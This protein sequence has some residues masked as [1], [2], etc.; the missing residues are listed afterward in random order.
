[1][2]KLLAA[3]RPFLSKEVL[4]SLQVHTT[5]ESLHKSIPKELLPVEYGG[6][7]YSLVELNEETK[8][9]LEE[10]ERREYLMNDEN[11]KIVDE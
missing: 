11:W 8:A 7:D 6:V 9:W 4:E 3:I 10:N 1:M 2:E 5:L